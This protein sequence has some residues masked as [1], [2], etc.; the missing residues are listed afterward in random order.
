MYALSARYS[1]LAAV[2]K[3]NRLRFS[4][5]VNFFARPKS[6]ALS[7]FTSA[8]IRYLRCQT[9]DVFNKCVGKQ[10]VSVTAFM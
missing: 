2:S 9:R 1:L 4:A 7:G 3:D 10:I 6:D 8:F 5:K